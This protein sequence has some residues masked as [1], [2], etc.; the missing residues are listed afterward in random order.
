MVGFVSDLLL[1]LLLLNADPELKAEDGG[2]LA[3]ADCSLD[4]AGCTPKGDLV[5]AL[6]PAIA[7]LAL[8]TAGL[9]NIAE[10]DDDNDETVAGVKAFVAAAVVIV[11]GVVVVGGRPGVGFNEVTAGL[12]GIVG[13]ERPAVVEGDGLRV[14]DAVV[15]V[16]ADADF[17]VK[18]LTRDGGVFVRLKGVVVVLGGFKAVLVVVLVV[19][20]A[21]AL[22]TPGPDA[23]CDLASDA[24]TLG[25]C[26]KL[27]N[28]F[29]KPPLPLNGGD[30]ATTLFTGA[31][32]AIGAAETPLA[33]AAFG[34]PPPDGR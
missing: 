2:S 18:P 9:V 5:A 29:C 6:G 22:V 32:R 21:L 24:A 15:G 12:E 8:A 33:L 11:V 28:V 27:L 19:V 4:F 1:P 16:E 3:F 14:R 20:M 23:F 34:P 13:F 31:T 26:R 17:A 10:D 7:G 25:F 30:V